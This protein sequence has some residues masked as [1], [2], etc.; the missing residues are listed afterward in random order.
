VRGGITTHSIVMRSS[1]GTVRW[2]KALHPSIEK[3]K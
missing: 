3:F 2:V 1:T